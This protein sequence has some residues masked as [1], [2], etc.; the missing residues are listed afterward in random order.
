MI[1]IAHLRT[2]FAEKLLATDDFQ[3]AFTKAVWVAYKAGIAA[4]VNNDIDIIL[5]GEENESEQQ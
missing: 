3:A 1:D 2:V 5:I 4:A